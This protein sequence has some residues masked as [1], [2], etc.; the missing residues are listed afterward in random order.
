MHLQ[1]LTS[2]QNQSFAGLRPVKFWLDCYR[3]VLMELRYGIW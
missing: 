1:L 3:V 2:Q